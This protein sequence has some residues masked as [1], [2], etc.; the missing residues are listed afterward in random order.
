MTDDFPQYDQLDDDQLA[1]FEALRAALIAGEE[2]G[3][4]I[5]FDVEAFL[6][7]MHEKHLQKL[8]E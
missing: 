1:K 7:E 4:S 6:A 2:S 3:P 5:E 8:P